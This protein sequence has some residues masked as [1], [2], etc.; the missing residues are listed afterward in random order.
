M[1]ICCQVSPASLL[2]VSTSNCQRV[3]VDESGMIRTQIWE[4]S[5]SE[6]VAVMERL[7]RYHPVTVAAYKII[8]HHKS[9]PDTHL[10]RKRKRRRNILLFEGKEQKRILF[11]HK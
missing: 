1:V 2:D 10:Y 3:Q 5:R 6:I 7:V 4:H 9:Q 8:Q 11:E